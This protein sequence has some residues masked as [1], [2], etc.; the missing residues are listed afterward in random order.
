LF[1]PAEWAALRSSLARDLF[2]TLDEAISD[3]RW[4]YRFNHNS[5]DGYFDELRSSLSSFQK[6]FAGD[7]AVVELLEQ[8]Q[9]KTAETISVL[10][11]EHQDRENDR[12]P[13]IPVGIQSERDGPD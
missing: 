10:E 3:W 11:S 6:E 7:P 13:P 2:P 12:A 1:T 4:S 5:P 9:G 8:S